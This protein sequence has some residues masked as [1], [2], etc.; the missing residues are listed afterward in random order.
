MRQLKFAPTILLVLVTS[1]QAFQAG[2]AQQSQ[3][4]AQAGQPTTQQAKDKS[5]CM[6][7]AKQQAGLGQSGSSQQAPSTG[8]ADKAGAAA[9]TSGAAAKPADNASQASSASSMAGAA[10][11]MAGSMGGAANAKV[12]QLAKDAYT[13]CMQKKGYKTK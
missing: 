3:A 8:A 7:W 12:T 10:E 11:Q 4:P 13:K 1:L 5:E 6:E 9:P 2:N